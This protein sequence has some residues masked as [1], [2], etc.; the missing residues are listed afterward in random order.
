M[1]AAA[2]G[3][4]LVLL[5]SQPSTVSIEGAQRAM[6]DVLEGRRITLIKLDGARPENKDARA[7]LWAVSGKRAVYPQLFLRLRNGEHEFLADAEAF[8]GLVECN[9]LDGRLDA[10]CARFDREPAA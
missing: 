3:T 6:L 5:S 10:M 8:S 1:L 4:A 7:A 2:P 9:E